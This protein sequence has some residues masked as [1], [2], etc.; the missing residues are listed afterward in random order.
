MDFLALNFQNAFDNNDTDKFNA[1]CVIADGRPEICDEISAGSASRRRRLRSQ[2]PAS[3][4]P[5]P[6]N[7]ESWPA[8]PVMG[9]ACVMGTAWEG[10]GDLVPA[11]D[12]PVTRTFMD[13]VRARI[14][15]L[16]DYSFGP[17][18]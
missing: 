9:T 13:V 10:T 15:K 6:A 11:F 5:T 17:H 3:R 16:K 8:V 7:V 12:V 1:L 2:P 4:I 18:E 14:P